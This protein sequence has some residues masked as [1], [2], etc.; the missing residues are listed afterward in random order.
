MT[1]DNPNEKNEENIKAINIHVKTI[2]IIQKQKVAEEKGAVRICQNEEE[3][4]RQ[5]GEA[6]KAKEEVMLADALKRNI[7]PSFL[8]SKISNLLFSF[9]QNITSR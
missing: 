8:F 5:W 3:H 2:L 9:L 1:G 7:K 6:E 4:R